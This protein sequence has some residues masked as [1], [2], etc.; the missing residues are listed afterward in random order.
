[1]LG[2]G[3]YTSSTCPLPEVIALWTSNHLHS[4]V[5][6]GSG[7]VPPYNDEET[8]SY[9][10]SQRE[11]QFHD[12]TRALHLSQ[13]TPQ[14]PS[15]IREDQTVPEESEGTSE[16]LVLMFLL[17]NNHLPT[18][19]SISQARD[20]QHDLLVLGRAFLD[21]CDEQVDTYFLFSRFVKKWSAIDQGPLVSRAQG[22]DM[23][24]RESD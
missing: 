20:E 3:Q 10:R 13:G 19:A 21:F 12:L 16:Q 11:Q 7:V 14:L 24:I 9:V 2:C 1:M 18:M 17:E 6:S 4:T 8:C 5:C 22:Y 23:I 15:H